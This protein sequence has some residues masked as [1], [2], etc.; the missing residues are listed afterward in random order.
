[1]VRGKKITKD[2]IISGIKEA[3]EAGV[4]LRTSPIQKTPHRNLY[5]T[6]KYYFR[7]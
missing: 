5:R 1:M 3:W 6:H 7:T 2:E 4:D